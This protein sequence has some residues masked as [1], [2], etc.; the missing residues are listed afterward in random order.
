[1]AGNSSVMGEAC[2][3]V[4]RQSVTTEK[5]RQAYGIAQGRCTP[6]LS[7]VPYRRPRT[8]TP[9][10]FLAQAALLAEKIPRQLRFKHTV[11]VWIACQQRG[12]GTQDAASSGWRGAHYFGINGP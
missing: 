5:P 3:W 12:G 1:M 2:Q 7:C 4:A 8:D 9:S 6:C 11:Q 10:M